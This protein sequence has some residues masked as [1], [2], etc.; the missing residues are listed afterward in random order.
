MA[1]LNAANE[2]AVA[3][4]LRRKIRFTEISR[5]I[6]EVMERTASG[7]ANDLNAILDADARARHLA[8]ELSKT[9]V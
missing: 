3:L 9:R 5:L 7:P 6:N 4:F 8:V 1:V 2:V